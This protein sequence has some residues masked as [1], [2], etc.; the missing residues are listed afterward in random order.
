MEV[1]VEEFASQESNVLARLALLREEQAKLRQVKR[2]EAAICLEPLA[3]IPGAAAGNAAR[4]PSARKQKAKE[5]LAQKDGTG[6]TR[7]RLLD[8]CAQ[9]F[10]TGSRD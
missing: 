1:G 8:S 9:F 5:E 4:P 7:I 10:L 2:C 3:L 6:V